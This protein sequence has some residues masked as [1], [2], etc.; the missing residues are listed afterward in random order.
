MFCHKS[1]YCNISINFY[2]VFVVLVLSDKILNQ[3][4]ISDAVA[5][6]HYDVPTAQ[7]IFASRLWC[8]RSHFQDE[9]VIIRVL[10]V[11]DDL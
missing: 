3:I 9:E 6:I 1:I 8:C 5:V 4:P 2:C 10:L 11:V 7:S